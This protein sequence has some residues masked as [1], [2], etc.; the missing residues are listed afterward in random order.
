[1]NYTIADG[2]KSTKKITIKL[3]KTEWEQA[4]E[5]AYQKTKNKYS[6]SGFRK[7]HVPMKVIENAYGKGVFFEDAVNE[8]FPKY[9]GEVLD[10][11]TSLF[12][13][14]RPSIDIDD[15]NDDGITLSA[16][17]PVKPEVKLGEYKGI[18]FDKIEYNVTDEDVDKE[19]EKL[20]ERNSRL[21][22][23]TDRAVNDGD[24]TTIDYS[25]SVDGVK[26]AGGTAEKQTLVIGSNSFIPGFEEQVKGMKIDE[27]KDITVTF[28]EEYHEKTLAGKEAVFH[29][30]LHEIKVKE[31]PEVDDEFIKDATGEE[32]LAKYKEITKAKLQEDNDKRASR[33]LEDAI[34]KA[35]TEKSEMEIPDA[36]IENQIDNMLQDMEYRLMYQGLK[37]EDYLKY[38]GETVENFRKSYRPR[39]EAAVKS[40]LVIDKI[41]A[42]ENIK[43]EESEID[44]KIAEMANEAKKDVEEYKKTMNA[45]TKEYMENEIV[46]NKLFDFLKAN[47]KIA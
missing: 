1:M 44:A 16:I 21:I 4:N 41:L 36:L 5:V 28:P 24:T 40:Q 13:V 7:G 17:V 18:K 19:I 39:A 26:F 31:L 20:R 8:A 33:E 38:T 9:Y 6:I 25:G 35:I 11:E 10:K 14:G 42:I 32:N 15:I 43:A 47:N 12:V 46:I 22:D 45:N 23:V 2:E 37:L 34:L 29:I 3:D 27:E 30:V